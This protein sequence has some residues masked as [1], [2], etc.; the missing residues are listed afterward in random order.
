MSNI[1]YFLLLSCRAKK[2]CRSWY[3]R[4]AKGRPKTVKVGRIVGAQLLYGSVELLILWICHWL[5]HLRRYYGG[6]AC[7][8]ARRGIAPEVFQATPVEKVL[9]VYRVSRAIDS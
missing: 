1:C 9:N 2:V 8:D 5:C 3:G 4:L 7:D 6:R